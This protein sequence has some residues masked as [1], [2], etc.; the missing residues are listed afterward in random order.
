MHSK[1]FIFALISLCLF[2]YCNSIVTYP[3][4]KNHIVR[5]M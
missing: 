1:P 4:N 2:S 5:N 3:P